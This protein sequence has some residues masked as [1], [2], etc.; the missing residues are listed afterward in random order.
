MMDFS[1]IPDVLQEELHAAWQQCGAALD[2]LPTQMVQAL[3]RVWAASPFT[4]GYCVKNAAE[5]AQVAASWLQPCGAGEMAAALRAWVVEDLAEAEVMR[6]LRR[7]RQREMAR[8][9]WRDL[10]G[11]AELAETLAD[12]S[13]LADVCVQ[14]AHDWAYAGLAQRLGTPCDNQGEAQTLVIVG[15]GKLGGAELNFSSDIDLIFT[16]PEPGMTAGTGKRL[17]NQEFFVK[18]GQKIISLLNQ[19]TADGWVFRVDMRLRPFGESGPLALTFATLENYCQTHARE[20]ERYAL[21]K[22]RAL[23]G[24]AAA[25]AR[26]HNL[27]YPFVFRKYF[28]FGAFAA[29]R[30]LKAQISREVHRKNREHDIKLGPG[31]IREIEFIVQVFQ[32]IRGGREKNLQQRHLLAALAELRKS[33]HL[34]ADRADAL[35]A[36][37]TFLRRAEN[38]LQ[39][40]DDQQTQCLPDDARARLRLALAMGYGD[41][42]TFNAALA[43]HRLHVQ[44]LFNEVFASAE[45]HEDAP[46]G[47]TAAEP[48]TQLWLAD[49]QDETVATRKLTEWGFA[50]PVAALETVRR[51]HHIQAA[52]R[53]S[54]L[55]QE[56]LDAAVPLILQAVCAY[57]PMPDP[58]LPVAADRRDVSWERMFRLV[59]AVLKR[60]V[61]LSLIIEHPHALAQVVQLCAESEWIAQQ[62]TRYPILLDELLD[63]RKLYDALRPEELDNAIQAQLAHV[64][65]EDLEE[66]MDLL[67]NFKRAHVLRT[68][69]GELAGR[70]T[71]EVASDYLTALAECMVR[72]VAAIAWRQLELRHGRPMCVENGVVRPAHFCIL[73]YG[74]AGGH[75]MSYNSDLDI[76]FLHDSTG[77]QQYTDGE[78]SLDNNVFFAR[79]VNRA[80]HLLTTRTPAGILYETDARLRPGGNSGLLAASL[81]SFASYQRQD[82]WTWEHQALARARAVAGDAILAQA[83]TA[84]RSE[85]L[86]RPRD[87]AQL[88]RDVVEMRQKMRTALDK[89]DAEFFDIKQGE[90][91][92]V[93]IEFLAQYAMLRWAGAYPDLLEVTSTLRMLAGIAAHGLFAAEDCAT[94]RA[95]YRTL[96]MESH[97]LALQSQPAR[98]AA[99]GL[100]T[101]RQAVCAIWQKLLLVP[102]ASA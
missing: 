55:A 74:K 1:D 96:R 47:R 16:Y 66:Q 12:L 67:R 85:I 28:D 59:E 41:W 48:F 20:W 70:L 51:L 5:F 13:A 23:T 64:A 15:M 38:R 57:T 72:Q 88:R 60:S 29:L 7:F 94:L 26:L 80:I 37:Y 69:A 93:D 86:R 40:M 44:Q 35:H 56:R 73:A 24:S 98:L 61:Y 9:A 30:D 27:L 76:V 92:L 18:L 2:A 49:W 43:Q 21:L 46:S 101:Q 84:I 39:A 81:H 82:A 89:S 99:D 83:F 52:G 53:L 10:A 102:E 4:R 50:R 32:L 8:I 90:G 87:V 91:G 68:A 54:R 11:W 95:T 25:R 3:P 63:T 34:G 78:N 97:R 75:E 58:A 79:L 71:L 45:D 36:A 14:T 100:R 19:P 6:R 77:E 42:N 22:A 31:G 65:L 62:L 17:D 33:G